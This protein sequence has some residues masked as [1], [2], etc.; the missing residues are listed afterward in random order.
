MVALHQAYNPLCVLCYLNIEI[1]VCA[2][3][4]DNDKSL[5]KWITQASCVYE[6]IISRDAIWVSELQHHQGTLYMNIS[7]LVF[8]ASVCEAD[9]NRDFVQWW[10]VTKHI[11]ADLLKCCTHVKY[12]YLR[13]DMSISVLYY[14]KLLLHDISE[15]NIIHFTALYH[16]DPYWY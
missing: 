16:F 13:I 6:L 4:W 3:V 14:I 10:K 8:C 5:L 12:N 1:P 2:C 11:Q 7:L 15:G 9:R